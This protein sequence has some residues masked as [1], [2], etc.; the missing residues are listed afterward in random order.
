MNVLMI[1]ARVAAIL[2]GVG[3]C[4]SAILGIV[5]PSLGADDPSWVP[6][7]PVSVA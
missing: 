1:L 5:D 3:F 6:S 7:R 2:F 4:A